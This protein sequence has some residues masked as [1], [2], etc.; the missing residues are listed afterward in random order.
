M[1]PSG[2]EEPSVS[3]GEIGAEPPRGWRAAVA[4]VALLA[5]GG[6]LGGFAIG[7]GT[8]EDLDAARAAGATSGEAAGTQDG[9]KRGY[10]AGYDIAAKQAFKKRYDD[11]YKAAYRAAFDDAGLD[12]PNLAEIEVD[13]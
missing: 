10:A 12:L 4:I 13:R 11:A 9:G 5:I 1:R 8:G 2:S 7:H 6:G 3:L